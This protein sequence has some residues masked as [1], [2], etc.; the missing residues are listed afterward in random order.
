MKLS[1]FDIFEGE[2]YQKELKRLQKKYKNI[3]KDCKIFI[4]SLDEI[5]DLGVNL[6]SNLYKAR[7]QNTDKN[8]GKSAGYRVISYIKIIESQVWLVYIYDKSELENMTEKQLDNILKKL[9]SN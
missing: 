2:T 4:D 1:G 7:I 5:A 8:K 3:K 9:F 6:G